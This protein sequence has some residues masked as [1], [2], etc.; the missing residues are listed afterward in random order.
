[1]K[2]TFKIFALLMLLFPLISWSQDISSKDTVI[3][4]FGGKSKIVFYINDKDDL[5]SLEQ[6]D[7]NAIANDLKSKLEVSDSGQIEDNEEERFLKDSVTITDNNEFT[8]E[9][10]DLKTQQVFLKAL[11]CGNS[12]NNWSV[13]AG[14]LA[15]KATTWKCRELVPVNVK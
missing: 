14:T 8:F 12:N 2:Y 5:K 13:Q 4:N 9:L 7:L 1:M 10:I 11:G 15:N 6:Y 3:V